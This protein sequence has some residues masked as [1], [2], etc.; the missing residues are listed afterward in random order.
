MKQNQTVLKYSKKIITL[1]KVSHPSL[2]T[3]ATQTGL[4]IEAIGIRTTLNNEAGIAAVF[5]VD[6]GETHRVLL[7]TS[8]N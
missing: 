7:S 1:I 5:I 2:D 6:A 3:A 8:P 4:V